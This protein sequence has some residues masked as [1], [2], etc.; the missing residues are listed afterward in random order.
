MVASVLAMHKV[1]SNETA[2]EFRNAPYSYHSVFS[3]CPF[4]VKISSSSILAKS[5]NR[6]QNGSFFRS[7]QDVFAGQR[8]RAVTK[9]FPHIS[10]ICM[11][12]SPWYLKLCI[13]VNN[14]PKIA[15][16]YHVLIYDISLD[17]SMF[18]VLFSLQSF[19]LYL[20]ESLLNWLHEYF[21]LQKANCASL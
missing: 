17:A 8:K 12:Q 16:E 20:V 11:T 5:C 19:C 3:L 7:D 6:F 2:Q 14:G 13:T 4:F 10:F 15:S 9:P 1:S 21:H 18:S